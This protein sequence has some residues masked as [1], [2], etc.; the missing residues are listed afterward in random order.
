M[1]KKKATEP[2]YN[3]AAAGELVYQ[4]SKASQ[5]GE[6]AGAYLKLAEKRPEL[7]VAIAA[8]APRAGNSPRRVADALRP[9]VGQQIEHCGERLVLKSR[10]VNRKHQTEFCV[11]GSLRQRI[12][13]ARQTATL[14]E[15]RIRADAFEIAKQLRRG[16]EGPALA[17]PRAAAPTTH[18]AEALRISREANWDPPAQPAGHFTPRDA[19][20]QAAPA[21][22]VILEEAVRVPPPVVDTTGWPRA[23][24]IHGKPD[25]SPGPRREEP[26]EHYKN[27][28]ARRYRGKGDGVE[29]ASVVFDP[30]HPRNQKRNEE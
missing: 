14:R 30:R 11:D 19:P 15:E 16:V 26:D 20:L 10:F 27:E 22:P 5:Q 4:L 6:P 17:L 24:L 25:Y 2:K 8:Y 23:W 3:V 13:K 18:S 9:L 29:L 21:T 7:A 1:T 12:I 28:E